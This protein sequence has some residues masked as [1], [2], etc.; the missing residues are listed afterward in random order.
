MGP[1]GNDRQASAM[2]FYDRAA[3]RQPHTHAVGFRRKKC[4]ENAINISWIDSYAG[5]F[6]LDQHIIEPVS[7]CL[8]S[9]NPGATL[10]G[11]HCIDRILDQV[12]DY[13]SQLEAIGLNYWQHII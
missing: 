5:I 2:V 8:D 1:T 6:D 13:L 9:Q 3:N 12:Y 4:I 7:F 10:H 11:T